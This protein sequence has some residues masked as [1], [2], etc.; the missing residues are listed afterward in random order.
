M[1]LLQF[2][3]A[4]KLAPNDRSIEIPVSE[5]SPTLTPV[6]GS[7]YQCGVLSSLTVTNPPETGH[8]RI[9]FRSGA[10]ATTTVFPTSILGLEQFFANAN[11]IYE[12]SVLDNRAVVGAWE[13]PANAE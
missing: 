7:C 10:T 8:Y 9:V 2:L 5:S 1:D 12:I 4:G 13:V 3:M 11:T 6:S